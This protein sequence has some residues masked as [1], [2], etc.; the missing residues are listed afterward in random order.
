MYS[1][2]IK[3]YLDK[4]NGKITPLEFMALI[5]SSPQ[6]HQVLLENNNAIYTILTEDGFRMNVEI[7][8]EPPAKKNTLK[9]DSN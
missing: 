1:H 7:I 3:Q 8:E 4:H 6:I 2:E 9:K 5:N